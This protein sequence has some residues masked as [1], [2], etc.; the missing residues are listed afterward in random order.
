MGGSGGG[1]GGSGG[2][3]NSGGGDSNNKAFKKEEEDA[4]DEEEAPEIE[5][6]EGDE[7]EKVF[8]K[9]SIYKYGEDGMKKFSIWNF[10]KKISSET[11]ALAFT[12]SSTVIVFAT[13]SGDTRKVTLIA[14]S[15]AFLVH[16]ISVMLKND[17]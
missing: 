10:I 13:L 9:N 3:S 1:S 11:A 15:C 8:T 4:E 17:K 14:T 16:Y 6:P 2:P 12:I 5:G 7:E